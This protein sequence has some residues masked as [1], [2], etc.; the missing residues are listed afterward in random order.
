MRSCEFLAPSSTVIVCI[1]GDSLTT[2][3]GVGIRRA[4]VLCIRSKFGR[5]DVGE[6]T[7]IEVIINRRGVGLQEF[8]DYV[9]DIISALSHEGGIV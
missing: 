7:T 1:E 3:G 9:C 4:M 5:L 8:R 6:M 2:V